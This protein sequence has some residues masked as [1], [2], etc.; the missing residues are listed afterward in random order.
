[1][2]FSDNLQA[3]RLANQHLGDVI[4]REGL[5]LDEAVKTLVTVL[6]PPA[7]THFCVFEAGLFT[8][9]LRRHGQLFVAVEQRGTAQPA[10]TK[11]RRIDGRVLE[12]DSWYTL[13][14]VPKEGACVQLVRGLEW[15]YIRER[16]L[17]KQAKEEG[18]FKWV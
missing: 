13:N 7:L 6:V 15:K 1:M 11:V 17:N 5:V 8:E 10:L 14:F 3:A 18:Q 12:L 16:D 9:H 2:K 4:V